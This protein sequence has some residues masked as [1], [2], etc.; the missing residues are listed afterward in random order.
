MTGT[1]QY[2]AN[3]VA[4][5]ASYGTGCSGTG[6]VLTLTGDNLP[7]TTRTF[8]ATC[9]GLA[10]GSIAFGAIGLSTSATPLSLLH[11]AGGAG[12][13]LLATPHVTV[14]LLP[15]AGSATISIGMPADTVFAG[16]VLRA[17]MID[18]ELDALLNITTITSS[19]GLAIT[20]GAL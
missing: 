11:P 19:N 16:A 13:D 1:C 20:N 18:I 6:G 7:W 5:T 4:A 15:V 8:H 9:T 10:N 12:C 14:L 3:P 2:Q 17:Q